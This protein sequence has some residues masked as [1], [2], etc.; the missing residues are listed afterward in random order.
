MAGKKSW[1]RFLGVRASIVAEGVRFRIARL[2]SLCQV[3]HR[4]EERKYI[5][6]D[7]TIVR[8]VAKKSIRS[9]VT[10]MTPRFGGDYKIRYHAVPIAKILHYRNSKHHSTGN[11]VGVGGK[12]FLRHVCLA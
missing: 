3:G 4:E 5:P 8:L 2:Q 9:M 12:V 1:R 10:L 6:R 11:H 7:M